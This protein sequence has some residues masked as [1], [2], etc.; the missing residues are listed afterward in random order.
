MT[1]RQY[2]VGKFERQTNYHP[3]EIAEFIQILE[4]LP[5]QMRM[6]VKGLSDAQ[7]ETEYREGGW[8]LRQVVHH[9]PDSHMN[10]FVRFKLA[11]TEENPTI[12]PY[13]EAAW[14]LLS[15]TR[16]T[17]VAVSLDLLEALHARWVILLRSIKPEDWKRT[18][19]HPANG[20]M[21]LEYALAL[22]AWH[23]RHHLAHITGTRT[24]MG[25]SV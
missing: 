14:A 17:P 24:R 5:A 12:K 8:T 21:T 11:L 20:S 19:N 6:A 10:S 13:D 9:V 18:F 25:W 7:L 4:Q 15:D 16:D 22:Y 23:S 1:E 2:P 3:N